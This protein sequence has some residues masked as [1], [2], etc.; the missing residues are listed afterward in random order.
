MR[1]VT[2]VTTAGR[3]DEQTLALAQQ[4]CLELSVPFLERNKQSVAKIMQ[5]YGANVL[6][7][8]KNRYEYY[9]FGEQVE[10]YFFHPNSAAFR[11]KRLARGERDPLVETCGLK[12]GDSFLDCTF[13]RG[14]DSIVAQ[15][16]VGQEGRVVG[17]EVNA[18][19]AFIG[20]IG[21]QTYPIAELPIAEGM[22]RIEVVHADAVEYLEQQA[23]NTFDVVYLDPMFEEVIE[24]AT[25]FQSLR[26]AGE[27]LAVS[28]KWIVEALRVSRRGVCIKAHFRSPL[29]EQ[30]GFVRQVRVTSK[31][32]FGFLAKERLV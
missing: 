2:V 20:R 22:H 8:G 16:V 31:F 24:E 18:A 12:K 30:F 1:E 14:S 15:F 4:A 27:H 9:P 17:L 23:D 6:V 13:G 25:N 28:K 7:A 21:V 3:P 32:H 5:M 29:F 19:V 26:Q 11:L 10:P